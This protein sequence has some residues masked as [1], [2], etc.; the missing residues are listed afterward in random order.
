VSSRIDARR[1]ASPAT[2]AH[3][4]VGGAILVVE[5]DPF[6]ADALEE[7]LQEF[8]YAVTVA[9][10]GHGALE[11]MQAHR[12]DLVLLDLTLPD[13]DGLDL[14]RQVRGDP[15]WNAVPII[16]RGSTTT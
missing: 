7:V 13:V 15:R 3:A 4:V 9:S 1:A 5:D 2:A 10:T 12:P 14:T 11:S 6:I 8:G 16:A